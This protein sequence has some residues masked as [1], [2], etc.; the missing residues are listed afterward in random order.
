MTAAGRPGGLSRRVQ[1]HSSLLPSVPQVSRGHTWAGGTSSNIICSNRLKRRVEDGSRYD[2]ASAVA[3]VDFAEALG[4]DLGQGS[5]ARDGQPQPQQVTFAFGLGPI[6]EGGPVVQHGVVV[7]PLHV[8]G[9][10]CHLHIDG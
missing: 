2:D 8:T 6:L 9:L 5:R 4:V 7:Y 3:D 10:E 1:R